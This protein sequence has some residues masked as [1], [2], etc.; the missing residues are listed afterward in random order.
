MLWYAY[1]TLQEKREIAKKLKD[2]LKKYNI[3]VKKKKIRNIEIYLD[4]IQEDDIVVNPGVLGCGV[5]ISNL[6]AKS[7]L[8]LDELSTKLVKIYKGTTLFDKYPGDLKRDVIF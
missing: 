8:K 1:F 4:I 2:L 7:R 3:D 5:L 6:S